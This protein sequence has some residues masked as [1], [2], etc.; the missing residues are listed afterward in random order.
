MKDEKFKVKNDTNDQLWEQSL[1]DRQRSLRQGEKKTLLQNG[2]QSLQHADTK[3]HM[4]IVG[5]NSQDSE[6][7][8]KETCRA[9]SYLHGS[10]VHNQSYQ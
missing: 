7:E 1:R 5:T 3:D 6:L 9:G 2:L 4:M 10:D 8:E